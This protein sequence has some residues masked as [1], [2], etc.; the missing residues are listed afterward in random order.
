MRLRIVLRSVLVFAIVGLRALSEPIVF[1]LGL[2]AGDG[3][4]EVDRH[5]R[6]LHMSARRLSIDFYLDEVKIRKS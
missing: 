6:D 1:D 2:L 3:H 5:L 4:F